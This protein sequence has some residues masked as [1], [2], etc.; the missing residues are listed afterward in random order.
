MAVVTARRVVKPERVGNHRFGKSLAQTAEFLLASTAN[1]MSKH[2]QLQLPTS[3]EPTPVAPPSSSAQPDVAGGTSTAESLT[4]KRKASKTKTPTELRR[5]VSTPHIRNLAI[6][7]PGGISPT[8]ADKRRNKLGYH[9]TSVACGHCRRRKIRCLM[10]TPEDPQGRCS[11]CIRLKKDCSF[12]PV[13][14]ANQHERS[15][16]KKGALSGAPP[17]SNSN[18]PRPAG[19]P[20]SGSV[21][22]LSGAIHFQSQPS[23]YPPGTQ[24]ESYSLPQANGVH[25]QQPP[26]GYTP[27]FHPPEGWNSG[28]SSEHSRSQTHGPGSISPFWSSAHPPASSSYQTSPRTSVGATAHSPF[29]SPTFNYHQNH[30]AWAQPRSLSFSHFEPGGGLPLPQY[31]HPSQEPQ[32]HHPQRFPFPPSLPSNTHAPITSAEQHPTALPTAAQ[33]P[34]NFTY[35]QH[36]QSYP[37]PQPLPSTHERQ[38]PESYAS[39]WYQDPAQAPRSQEEHAPYSNPDVYYPHGTHAG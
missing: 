31:Q 11:N 7:E 3:S 26:Y 35:Q 1:R 8:T 18:S 21:E 13:T 30:H 27:T 5:A 20:N 9:R 10:P 16:G 15:G 37:Q 22:E 32:G 17:A 28:Y 36:W 39:Q 19:G 12:Y 23:Q 2:F 24:P 4:K 38:P 25:Y 29:E 6:G 14:E 34:P 33:A